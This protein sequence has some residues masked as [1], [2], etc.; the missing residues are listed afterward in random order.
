M[1]LFSSVPSMIQLNISETTG[2]KS[3]RPRQWEKYKAK[4]AADKKRTI[5]KPRKPALKYE[6]KM[7]TKRMQDFYNVDNVKNILADEDLGFSDAT[8]ERVIKFMMSDCISGKNINGVCI[9]LFIVN[10]AYNYSPTNNNI[11]ISR[12]ITSSTPE[13]NNP[14][15][16]TLIDYPGSNTPSYTIGFE[17]GT[18]VD[19]NAVFFPASCHEADETVDLLCS[20]TNELRARRQESRDKSFSDV[21]PSVDG[22]SRGG[23]DNQSLGGF[24]NGSGMS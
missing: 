19:L 5:Q 13:F 16:I 8:T 11:E 6:A 14:T 15:T 24:S 2:V 9:N 17:D 7:S 18:T 1:L 4:K 12:K 3:L 23:S 22:N 20:M 10:V 21:E